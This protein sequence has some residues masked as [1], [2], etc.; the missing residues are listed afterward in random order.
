MVNGKFSCHRFV[1]C[2]PRM[3]SFIRMNVK[4]PCAPRDMIYCRS[5]GKFTPMSGPCLSG[6]AC[7]KLYNGI[8]ERPAPFRRW[9]FFYMFQPIR[10]QFQ[11]IIRFICPL[12]RIHTAAALPFC[13]IACVTPRPHG[14]HASSGLL[15]QDAQES[16]GATRSRSHPPYG[17]TINIVIS[18]NSARIPGHD[19]P[20]IPFPSRS[21]WQSGSRTSLGG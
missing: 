7:K 2:F 21:S 16:T 14:A 3:S 9:P 5:P 13:Q 4:S 18:L 19:I 12:N 11:I 17:L 15:A 20:V 10:I 8:K 1:K 6:A